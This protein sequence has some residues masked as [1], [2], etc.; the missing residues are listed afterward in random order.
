ATRRCSRRRRRTDWRGNGK[1]TV[2]SG[3]SRPSTGRRGGPRAARSSTRKSMKE[4][5]MPR[6]ALITGA[7]RGLG[8][9]L[10]RELA[11]SGWSL[12]VDAREPEALREA[13]EELS[14]LT[15]EGVVAL[16]GDV[17]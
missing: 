8:F 7:S 5:I 6:T 1:S 16:A 4:E 14:A 17:S 13:R 10:A 3:C 12:V 9:A 2:N 11:G 15:Q